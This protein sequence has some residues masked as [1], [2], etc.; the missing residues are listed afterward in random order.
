MKKA[1]VL[2]STGLLLF[3]LF[4]GTSLAERKFHTVPDIFGGT[5]SVPD[6]VERVA[7]GWHAGTQTMLLLNPEKLVTCAIKYPWVLEM[8]PWA[9]KL[10]NPLQNRTF[11]IEELFKSDPH[12]FFGNI[13]GYYAIND[14]VRKRIEDAGI[15]FMN[16]GFY[17][18]DEL[19]KLVPTMARVLGDERA[20]GQAEKF[21]KYLDRNI[22]L[23]K[24][25]LADI[26][27]DEK[28]VMYY[29]RASAGNPLKAVGH[30]V[31]EANWIEALGGLNPTGKGM[32]PH[33]FIQEIS[34]EDFL[35]A[36]PDIIFIGA[37]PSGMSL[38]EAKEMVT[39]D[40]RFRGVSAVKNKRL[41]TIPKGM[42]YWERYSCE[43]ALFLIWA[44]KTLYP[45]KFKDINVYEEAKGFYKTFFDY[46]L[47]E[48]NYQRMVNNQ[49]PAPK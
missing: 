14:E 31:L 24:S 11:N 38:D 7:I 25:R 22:N 4:I 9:E 35:V 18:Y 6:K 12:M 20:L 8:F 34:L 10:P 28:P 42:F 39:K 41:I 17:N 45:D 44:A 33:T 36:D 2:M 29:I 32:P 19:R 30:D 1:F 21:V 16:V 13:G 3:T 37:V 27:D 47:S 43:N 40:A 49:G 23:I 26:P 48:E 5:A 15:G 46:D